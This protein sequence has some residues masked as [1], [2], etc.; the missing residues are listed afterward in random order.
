MR[1]ACCGRGPAAPALRGFF[2]AED[3]VGVVFFKGYCEFAADRGV[4]EGVNLSCRRLRVSSALAVWTLGRVC[5]RRWNS[6]PGMIWISPVG[7]RSGASR[8]RV[9]I[10][11]SRMALGNVRSRSPS[12]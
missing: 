7:K 2:P 4:G 6:M 5:V 11:S 8:M 1:F 10:S 3:G 12:L 9:Q